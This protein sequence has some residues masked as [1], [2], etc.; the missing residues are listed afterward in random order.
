MSHP[1][2]IQ[3]LTG[4]NVT[5][6]IN[7]NQ[8]GWELYEKLYQVLNL[9]KQKGWHDMPIICRGYRLVCDKRLS[10]Q[11]VCPYE[12]LL[13]YR[14]LGGLNCP[15]S[16]FVVHSQRCIH[17]SNMASVL[18]V[19]CLHCCMCY[20]CFLKYILEEKATILLVVACPICD[21]VNTAT[22]YQQ[23]LLWNFGKLVKYLT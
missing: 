6:Y 15:C 4:S 18:F 19:D 8:Y 7:L 13:F 12:R 5:L 3:Q 14:R 20:F 2:I 16:C 21:T 22:F 23:R 11:G 17:C 9:T 1:I 10:E